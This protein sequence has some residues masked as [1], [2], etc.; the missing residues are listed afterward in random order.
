MRYTRSLEFQERFDHAAPAPSTSPFPLYYDR[1]NKSHIWD[2][3]GNEYIDY[4]LG[5]GSLLL[6]HNPPH[7]IDAITDQVRK[8]L[9]YC[10]PTELDVLLSE[11]ICELV[12][13]AERVRF[14]SSGSEGVHGA[15][16]LARGITGRKK[17]VRFEGHYHGWFDNI[18]WKLSSS[19]PREGKRIPSS[20]KPSAPLGQSEEDGA[21]LFILHWNDFDGVSELF[22]S[23]GDDI[24]GIILDPL[25]TSHGVIPPQPGFLQTLR[26]LCDRYE[27][28]LIFDEVVTGFRLALGG[29]SEYFGVDPDLAVY[30]KALGAGMVVSALA[31]R[32]RIMERWTDCMPVL[33]GTFASH[34]PSLAAALAGLEMLSAE[35]GKLLSKAHETARSLE[36]GLSILGER[37][38]LPLAVRRAG[39]MLHVSFYPKDIPSPTDRESFLRTDLELT[40]RIFHEIQP[41]GIRTGLDGHW[42][43]STAHTQSDLD[44]TLEAM[45][46]T[47]S[48][49]E[50]T[51]RRGHSRTGWED[52]SEPDLGSRRVSHIRQRAFAPLSRKLFDRYQTLRHE[53]TEEIRSNPRPNLYWV[54]GWE[55]THKCN[56]DC[57]YCG[58][59]H[60]EG[61]P[62]EDL[63]RGLEQILKAQPRFIWVTG[64][65]PTLV[66]GLP[67]ILKRIKRETGNPVILLS[68]NFQRPLSVYETFIESGAIDDL[69]ITLDGLDDDC[70]LNRGVNGRKM[71]PRMVELASSHP[72]IRYTIATVATV[73]NFESL[74]A[75]AETIQRE[76]PGVRHY[77][78]PMNPGFHPKSV[79]HNPERAA[80]YVEIVTRLS[81]RFPTIRFA[82]P[83]N[84]EALPRG[85]SRT[86]TLG[87]FLFGEDLVQCHRQYFYVDIAPDGSVFDCRLSRIFPTLDWKVAKAL[88]RNHPLE[89]LR[90]I[91]LISKQ[92][93]GDRGYNSSCSYPCPCMDGIGKIIMAENNEDPG[94]H[95]M[96]QIEG[97]RFRPE[98]RE[99]ATRFIQKNI[100]PLFEE[101]FF[102]RIGGCP[103]HATT[104]SLG[105]QHELALDR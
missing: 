47:L 25:M 19:N 103:P 39:P 94:L 82:A 45:R 79:G 7:V 84:R 24:A 102:D 67:A 18:A 68:T 34:P 55:V 13:F 35:G 78:W 77:I 37:T 23:H 27:A 104:E 62:G 99:S 58:Q 42:F 28:V 6:G 48:H 65:E 92:R 14:T 31:G 8:G 101:S 97:T 44:V 64:G 12:P 43:V 105:D 63:Q 98:E 73:H 76:L 20:L 9:L 2:A 5:V 91:Q 80:R 30:G 52:P 26:N 51:S 95:A 96:D 87:K 85:Q 66:R 74:P 61:Y 46:K 32:A 15:L 3:D 4:F 89:I 81:A 40:R 36:E 41:H 75:L 22:S 11:K 90:A 10:A 59:N 56:L 88:E 17:I 38:S 70:R 16:R 71:L 29:A 50:E 21:N 86:S 33:A 100:N 49:L 54:A 53:I 60:K 1:G 83:Q 93:N 72:E 69:L 57:V